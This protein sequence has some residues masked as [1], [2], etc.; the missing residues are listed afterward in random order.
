[1]RPDFYEVIPVHM[2]PFYVAVCAIVL[3]LRG[4]FL[5]SFGRRRLGL[6]TDLHTGDSESFSHCRTECFIFTLVY[7]AGQSQRPVFFPTYLGAQ[8]TVSSL[9]TSVL[10]T[11][12]SQHTGALIEDQCLHMVHS[13]DNCLLNVVRVSHD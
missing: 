9:P 7:L 11:A 1:M 2:K 13:Q 6:V 3:S 12:F 5:R 4:C 8:W 10:S